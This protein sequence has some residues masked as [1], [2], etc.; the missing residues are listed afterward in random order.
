MEKIR[1]IKDT[2]L[3]KIGDISNCSKKSAESAIK[4]GYAEYVNEEFVEGVGVVETEPQKYIENEDG[5]TTNIT[6]EGKKKEEAEYYHWKGTIERTPEYYKTK[7]DL[8]TLGVPEYLWERLAEDFDFIKETINPKQKKSGA[9][10][11]VEAQAKNFID[12]QPIF[13]DRA[14]IWMMWSHEKTRWE[15]TDE[16]DI[17]NGIKEDGADTINSKLRTEII[18]ALKQMGRKNMPEV[19][20]NNWIQFRDKIVDLTTGETFEATPKY[21]ITNPIPYKIGESEDTPTL[22]K[23]FKE[24]VI[25]E[26]LQ[27]ESYVD[28]LYEIIA[29]SC[30]SKQFLQR[31]FA[32]VGSGSN[33]KGVFLSIVEKFL[34]E[35]NC[36]STELKILA[37]NGFETSALY[38][39]Q[40]CFMGEVDAYDMS[41]TN[42]LKKLSGE[43]GIRYCFKGKTPFTEKSATTCFMNTN[44]LPVTPDK[45]KGFYRRWMIIDFPHEFPVGKDIL[46]EIPEKEYNNLAKKCL[47]I[48]KELIKRKTFTNEG[49]LD[50]RIKRYEDRSNPLMRFVED[51]CDD[52]IERETPLQDFYKSINKYLETNRLRKMTVKRIAKSLKEEG[53]EISRLSRKINEK[54]VKTN[55]IIGIGLSG[56]PKDTKDYQSSN[57]LLHENSSTFHSPT[58]SFV[59]SDN[60]NLDNFT[61][62]EIEEAGLSEAEI[63]NLQ[64]DVK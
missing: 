24:W 63:N 49:D 2:E 21:F 27:D 46:A 51:S 48:S 53:F 28:T 33:G 45:S 6:Q 36:S 58:T 38:K 42:L 26:G 17:L 41:N 44:S 55:I 39:R 47:R 5:T 14:G 1:F 59:S 31:L 3:K 23:Y 13:Y 12:H 8:K 52:E 9:I 35:D 34:G 10:F 25:M 60:K 22:D 16:T 64:G 7:A 11:T 56:T 54:M 20:K 32:F 30:M 62:E 43:D 40:A 4:N 15:L 57:T 29:Y 18:N 37:T 50:L 61:K 19:V